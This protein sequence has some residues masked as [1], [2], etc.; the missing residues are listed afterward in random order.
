MNMDVTPKIQTINQPVVMIMWIISVLKSQLV[1]NKLI[2]P[3]V[4]TT[5]RA[6]PIP[7]AKV[8]V[9]QHVVITIRLIAQLIP[10]HGNHRFVMAQIILMKNAGL[11]LKIAWALVTSYTSIMN[12]AKLLGAMFQFNALVNII[13][14]FMMVKLIN[15]YL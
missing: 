10:A 5:C 2:Q 8:P 3:I 9:I 14:P 7:H 13:A 6:T 12:I 1:F 11:F 15:V 4:L